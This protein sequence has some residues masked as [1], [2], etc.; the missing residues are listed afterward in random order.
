MRTRYPEQDISLDDE[1]GIV[2]LPDVTYITSNENGSQQESEAGNQ[3]DVGSDDC[4]CYLQC[5]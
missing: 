2:V 3:R 1:V 4:Y 5:G